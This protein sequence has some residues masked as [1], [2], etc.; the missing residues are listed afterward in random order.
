[1]QTTHKSLQFFITGYFS[2]STSAFT[3]ADKRASKYNSTH[4]MILQ[5]TFP[6][7][8]SYSFGCP[9]SALFKGKVYGSYSI[10]QYTPER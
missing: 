5:G 2:T 1:M 8:M 3:S 4:S 10:R 9:V 7:P 6:V